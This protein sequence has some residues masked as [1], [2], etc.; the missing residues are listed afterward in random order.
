M[1]LEE[2]QPLLSRKVPAIIITADRTEEVKEEIASH[3]AQL[4]TK[5]IR[6]AALRAMINKTIATARASES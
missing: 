3:S 5:P 2:I 6:P 1:A 4:L